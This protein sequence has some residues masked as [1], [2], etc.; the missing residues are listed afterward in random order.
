M[1]TIFHL[2]QGSTAALLHF[3][4]GLFHLSLTYKTDV[5]KIV[6]I[7]PEHV[8]KDRRNTHHSL[9]LKHLNIDA[10]TLGSTFS[11]VISTKRSLY[12]TRTSVY[13][14]YH[15]DVRLWEPYNSSNNIFEPFRVE[16]AERQQ[17]DLCTGASRNRFVSWCQ[18]GIAYKSAL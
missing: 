5:E 6:F 12:T 17:Y 1:R 2:C 16:A 10:N 13:N 11:F 9:Y 8:Q 18:S 3:S 7:M 4:I 15:V 14:G